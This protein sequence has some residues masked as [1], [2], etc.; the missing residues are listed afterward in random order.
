MAVKKTKQQEVEVEVT[1]EVLA[2]EVEATVEV[3]ETPVVEVAEPVVEEPKVEV[4]V[5]SAMATPKKE[6]TVK[7]RMRVD[8]RC[9][10]AMVRYDLKKGQTYIV[11]ENV[12]RILDKAGFLAPLN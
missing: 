7:I 6:G 12:K 1:N 8:H 5:K 4:D 10:I 2:P 9:T 3:E 11:P